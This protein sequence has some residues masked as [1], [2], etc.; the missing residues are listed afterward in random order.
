MYLSYSGWKVYRDCPRSYMFRYITKP[1]LP[2]PDNKVGALYGIVVGT[3][4]ENFYKQ[5]L[6]KLADP[7]G[8]LLESAEALLLE[9]IERERES[10]A[11]EAVKIGADPAVWREA[12]VRWKP[13]PGQ[14]KV[15]YNSAEAVMV[16]I[17]RAIPNGVEI[18]RQHGF[19]APKVG[20]EVVL[21]ADFGPHR[22]VG[23]ADFILRRPAPL[24]DLLITDGKGS[25]HRERY[26][27][28]N[29]LHWYSML[30]R[31]HT[32]RLPDK[33]CFIFWRSEPS[34]AVLWHSV[35]QDEVNQLRTDVLADVDAIETGKVR[36]AVATPARKLDVVQEHFPVKPGFGCRLCSFV[37]VCETGRVMTSKK[38]DDDSTPLGVEDVGL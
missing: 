20:S 38:T 16:D 10:A 1:L 6:W 24:N 21:D 26:T 29:Q 36:T 27:D 2:L 8:A 30:F 35:T 15:D 19:I 31:R 18:I 4:F 37:P 17:R 34:D 12:A 28:V 7:A 23:R 11:K 14:K 9:T 13:P 33:V 5:Q 22:L 32:K 25:R 3:L